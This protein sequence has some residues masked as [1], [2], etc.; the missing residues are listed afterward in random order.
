MGDSLGGEAG[1]REGKEKEGKGA[2]RSETKRDVAAADAEAVAVAAARRGWLPRVY[3]RIYTQLYYI[4]I[5]S[6]WD[7]YAQPIP[8]FPRL[9]FHIFLLALSRGMSINSSILFSFSHNYIYRPKF[10]F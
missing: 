7:L 8:L 6:A 4:G 5:Y 3:T 10:I 1:T 2:K 9:L